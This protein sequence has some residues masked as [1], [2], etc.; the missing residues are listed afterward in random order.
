MGPI[1]RRNNSEIQQLRMGPPMKI[2]AQ[3]NAKTTL[4]IVLIANFL[5][6][7][8]TGIFLPRP[9]RTNV[10]FST[11]RD[12]PRRDEARKKN[13]FLLIPDKYV[14]K[15]AA[16]SAA[17][18]L[19]SSGFVKLCWYAANARSMLRCTE[20]DGEGDRGLKG[21]L[22]GCFGNFELLR[23][24]GPKKQSGVLGAQLFH[25]RYKQLRSNGKW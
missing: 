24:T 14:G 3:L 21:G 17:L 10:Y 4:F 25:R 2:R 7:W 8:I 13:A 11:R 23:F 12:E 6:A 9:S 15:R 16:E 19:R 18:C 5:K 1:T 20:G 22:P